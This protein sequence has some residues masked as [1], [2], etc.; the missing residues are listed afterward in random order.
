VTLTCRASL[1]EGRPADTIGTVAAI[2]GTV[3]PVLQLASL[4]L[5]EPAGILAVLCSVLAVIFW[6]ES[7]PLLR[8]VFTLVPAIVFCYFIPTALNAAGLIPRQSPLYEWVKD[9][10]LP[11]SLVWLTLA[12]DVPAL[13]GLGGRAVAI[14]LVSSFSLVAGGPLAML[15][16][17]AFLPPDAWQA[18]AY[19]AGS[20]IGGA[21]NAVALVRTVGAADSTIAPVVI[22]DVILSY[23]WMGV[24]LALAARRARLDRWLRADAA[25]LDA[26]GN[27]HASAAGPSAHARPASVRDLAGLL[28]LGIGVAVLSRAAGRWI[29]DLPALA[30]ARE[31]LGPEAWKFI[32]ATTA[33]LSLSFTRARTLESVGA[34]RLGMFALYLLITCIGAG[35]DFSRL[36]QAGCYLA[37]GATWIGCHVI[38]LF[39][40]GRLLRAPFFLV[41]VSSQANIGGPVSAPIVAAA[42]HPALAP[43]GAVL[44]IAGYVLGTYAGLVC[45]RLCRLVAEGG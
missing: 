38:L 2:P 5:R 30:G 32:L 23:L 15:V 19:L 42:F 33:G 21:A 44:A 29:A 6:L 31:S 13:L 27:R 25:F 7:R 24:L 11:A 41:A 26:L 39:L 10:L 43:V 16:W 20:W 17:K 37:F 22:V 34:S 12:L 45:C 35:A 9:F 8:R 18:S 1:H 4:P 36:A 3:P 14:F 40:A 28:A